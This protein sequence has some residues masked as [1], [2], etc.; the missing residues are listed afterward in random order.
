MQKELGYN[1]IEILKGGIKEF[2]SEILNF[3][4]D[5]IPKNKI[6][7]TT[8]NFREKASIII[9]E[10]IKNNKPVGKVEKKLKRVV[11]GC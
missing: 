5:K 11:G 6:E 1:N 7:E 9:P 2:E 3:K 4:N 10:M 8:F